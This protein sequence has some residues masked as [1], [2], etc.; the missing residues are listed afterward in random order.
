VPRIAC[1]PSLPQ[2]L[3][4][5]SPS[6]F[7]RSPF[8]SHGTRSR[9]TRSSPSRKMVFFLPKITLG[10][11][12]LM[13]AM[14]AFGATERNEDAPRWPATSRWPCPRAPRRRRSSSTPRRRK[15]RK[16]RDAP[17]GLRPR[18]GRAHGLRV[19]GGG[20][21]YGAAAAPRGMLFYINTSLLCEYFLCSILI[22][23]PLSP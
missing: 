15:W 10:F 20:Q 9:S 18:G 21:D 7:S 23:L 3:Q 5:P 13:Q 17:G 2:S 11:L 1:D 14:A 22:S 16:R 19:G 6:F 4:S 12:I 8:F